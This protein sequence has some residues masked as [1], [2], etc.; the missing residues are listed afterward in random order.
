MHS[1]HGKH[2]RIWLFRYPVSATM[3][4]CFAWD[5][6]GDIVRIKMQMLDQDKFEEHVKYIEQTYAEKVLW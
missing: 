1:L 2:I 6:R 4:F 3:N 5:G